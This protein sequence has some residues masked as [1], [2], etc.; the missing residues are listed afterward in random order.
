M[1]GAGGSAAVRRRSASK[2]PA[3]VR[4]KS[5]TGLAL[6]GGVTAPRIIVPGATTAITRRTSYRKAFLAPWDP[7][8]RQ[9]W[10]YALGCAQAKTDVAVHHGM[11]VLNHHH[12]HVTPT[13]ANLPEFSERVHRDVSVAVSTLM[14]RRRYDAP[15][16]LWDGRVPHYCR[17]LDAASQATGIVYEQVNCVA[18]GL[19]EAPEEMPDHAFHFG[20]WKRGYIDIERPKVYFSEARPAVVRLR[21]TPP[22]LLYEA[23]GGDIDALI[24]H[25]CGLTRDAVRALKAQRAGRPVRGADRV[26]RIHPWSEPRSPRERG[27]ERVPTFRI[28]ARGIDGLLAEAAKETAAFRGAY[29]AVR[30]ARRDGELESVFPY[31]TYAMRVVHQ[32]PV[33]TTWLGELVTRP[34]PTLLE[35]EARL[36]ADDERRRALRAGVPGLVEAAREAL[37]EEAGT[38]AERDAVDILDPASS[39][40]A[41]GDEARAESRGH[42]IAD[43]VVRHDDDIAD[44]V[45]RH[46]IEGETPVVERTP[47]LVTLRDDGGRTRRSGDPP[48]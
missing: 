41:R 39:G 26:R 10:L 24:R 22:P 32:A 36:A 5:G 4:E 13:K 23:F 33:D 3:I 44:P 14:A 16:E 40:D 35:V 19:V 21:V 9:I 45:V 20:L 1:A 37:R 47:R 31:G 34:G 48:E 8:V 46:R 38:L 29:A 18:A 11:L 6:A 7:M 27:G 43:P 25:M 2:S 42:D 17:A 15:H 12:L 28:G 30:V